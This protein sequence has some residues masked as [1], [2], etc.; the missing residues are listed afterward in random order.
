MNGREKLVDA[1]VGARRDG[2]GLGKTC[3]FVRLAAIVSFLLAYPHLRSLSP[4]TLAAYPP[5][6]HHLSAEF[7]FLAI[8]FPRPTAHRRDNRKLKKLLSIDTWR[9]LVSTLLSPPLSTYSSYP[10]PTHSSPRHL[11]EKKLER[12]PRRRRKGK[13]RIKGGRAE[14]KEEEE[15]A[16][17]AAAERRDAAF[18]IENDND[19]AAGRLKIEDGREYGETVADFRGSRLHEKTCIERAQPDEGKAFPSAA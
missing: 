9:C 11:V 15:E 3:P 14:K 2:G 8:P 6:F 7:S 18:Q 4:S 1:V 13:R 5:S 12:H 16:T 19:N 17:T 10:L